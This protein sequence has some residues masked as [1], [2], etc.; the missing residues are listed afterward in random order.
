MAILIPPKHC[1]YCGEEI[2]KV[3]RGEHI[4][5]QAIGGKVYISDVCGVKKVCSTCNNESLAVIDDELCKQSFVAAVAVVAMNKQIGQ[6]WDIDHE[7]AGLLVEA[8]YDHAR[9]TMIHHPQIIFDGEEVQIRA[10]YDDMQAYGQKRFKTDLI[11][12]LLEAHRD[13][14]SGTKNRIV[15]KPVAPNE[16]LF[17]FLRL[18]PRLF[19]AKR[20][21][22]EIKPGMT[23]ELRYVD[24][25]DRE[26]AL[27]RI[28]TL[29]PDMEFPREAV[30][31]TAT[32]GQMRI[33][34]DQGKVLRAL[35][36]IGLNLLAAFCPHTPID[37]DHVPDV[38]DVI[39]GDKIVDDRLKVA[40][41]FVHAENLEPIR[42]ADA[43]SF[44]LQHTGRRWDILC[45][46]FGGRI[47]TFVNI[48]GPNRE[49]WVSA[50]VVLPLTG[51]FTIEQQSNVYRHVPY[52][53][54]WRDIHKIAPTLGVVNVH[55]V[56]TREDVP[57]R[58]SRKPRTPGTS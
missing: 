14:K 56:T 37:R 47:G 25:A 15:F 23:F 9:S 21:V 53:I 19:S 4:V 41:G 49:P 35:A 32:L 11:T 28:E 43:H 16:Q 30:R 54:E 7:A 42:V 1:I 26:K 3:N 2:R 12:Y 44:L 58:P 29:T 55:T 27:R 57:F 45:S 46:L 10:D 48:P 34:F 8:G 33:R 50:R 13:F 40:N 20:S 6:T 38:F 51:E 18:P 31:L 36:K 52:T 17:K 5:P 22:A 39:L 24:A